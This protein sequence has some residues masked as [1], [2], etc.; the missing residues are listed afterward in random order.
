M[1]ED[2]LENLQPPSE[3]AGVAID[4]KHASLT[5]GV[6]SSQSEASPIEMVA[7]ISQ[8]P[9]AV[10]KG[11][12]HGPY[13]KNSSSSI[14]NGVETPDGDAMVLS[15]GKKLDGIKN[16]DKINNLVQKEIALGRVGVTREK[17]YRVI[18]Q[19]LDA[20]KWMDVVDKQGNV[21][22]EWVDDIEK[23]RWGAEMAIKMF[24]DMIERK[25]IEMDVGDKTL[26]RLR[27]LSVA[28]LKARAADLILGKK[29][30]VVDA[31]V[32]RV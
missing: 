5:V 31:E 13:G 2:E 3:S 18:A 25:E 19:A 26:D 6:K 9:V 12:S 21:K 11:G 10:E 28:E 4:K 1:T 24:G 8:E 20:K 22:Q 23:Q 16:L 14:K 7:V 29:G 27:S 15:T 17:A 32:T 30:A